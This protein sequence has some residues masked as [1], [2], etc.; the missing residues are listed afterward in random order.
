[1]WLI[2]AGGYDKAP[3]VASGVRAFQGWWVFRLVG[4]GC[5]V[6]V[7]AAR[8]RVQA[9]AIAVAHRQVVSI[10][11]RVRRAL[12]VTRAATCRTR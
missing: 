12:R 3:G 4:A 11:S 1:M 5:R 10:A 7:N 6:Q 9:V 2:I 8:M